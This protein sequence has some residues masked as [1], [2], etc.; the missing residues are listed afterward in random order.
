MNFFLR[1]TWIENCPR[2]PP[3]ISYGIVLEASM[4][5][6]ALILNTILFKVLKSASKSRRAL[7]LVICTF[8]SDFSNIIETPFLY[9]F[10]GVAFFTAN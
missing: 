7:S 5:G 8:P 2:L 6:R 1:A 3:I 9:L 4:V 10:K